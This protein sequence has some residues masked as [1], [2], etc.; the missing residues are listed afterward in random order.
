MTV[1]R[2]DPHR[3]RRA[4]RRSRAGAARP[5]RGRRATFLRRQPVGAIGMVLVLIFGLA[6]IFADVAR[7]L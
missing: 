5:V 4:A 2:P 7:A 3:R 1:A 6:G